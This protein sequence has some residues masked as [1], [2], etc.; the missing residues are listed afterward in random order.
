MTPRLDPPRFTWWP[1][2]TRAYRDWIIEIV[3]EARRTVDFI[4]TRPDLFQPD[5]LAYYGYSWGGSLGPLVLSLDE[6]ITAA[7]LLVGG[8]AQ[9]EMSPEVDPFNF[10]SRVFVPTLMINADQDTIIPV[11]TAQRPLFDLLGTPDADKEWLQHPG[12]HAATFFRA[13]RMS[14]QRLDWL[15]RH[16]GPVN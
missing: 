7:I 15:D 14:Q 10:S 13:N 3:N 9:T 6:R 1:D 8:L 2:T 11:E 5:K 12:G 16:L 4:E